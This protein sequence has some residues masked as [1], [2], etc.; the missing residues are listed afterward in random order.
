METLREKKKKS[1]EERIFNSA[2]QLF[3][4]KGFSET[5]MKEVAQRAE[6]GVGTLYNYFSYKNDL[7]LEI[8]EKK[9]DQ[10]IKGSQNL[11]IKEI[12]IHKNAYEVLTEFI[13]YYLNYFFILNREIWSEAFIAIFSSKSYVERGMHM[14]MK[15]ISQLQNLLKKLNQKQMIAGDL[16]LESIAHII[17]SALTFQFISFVTFSEME[18]EDLYKSIEKQIEIIYRGI[19]P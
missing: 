10:M 14:D 3:N 8:M 1:R 7:L 17:Y 4:E 12:P 19:K 6:L 11:I 9:L 5:T 15:I 18:K 13:K 16:D 2:I